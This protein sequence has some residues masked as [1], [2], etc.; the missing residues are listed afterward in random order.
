MIRRP[1]ISTLFP[2]TTLFRS[3]RLFGVAEFFQTA[4]V[5]GLVG[6]GVKLACQH[7]ELSPLAKRR[8]KLVGDSFHL[9]GELGAA[10]QTDQF[11]ER[12]RR[13]FVFGLFVIFVR[14]ERCFDKWLGVVALAL[15]QGNAGAGDA[16]LQAS[17]GWSLGGC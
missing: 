8:R 15:G 1:P 2:Y 17:G 16:R 9:A 14:F 7:V 12:P 10:A 13:R 11:H 5:T 6:I 4:D 3:R